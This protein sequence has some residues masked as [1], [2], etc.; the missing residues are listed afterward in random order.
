MLCPVGR[1]EAIGGINFILA[2][3]GRQKNGLCFRLVSLLGLFGKAQSKHIHA[4]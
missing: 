1:L 4:R 3:H 2:W